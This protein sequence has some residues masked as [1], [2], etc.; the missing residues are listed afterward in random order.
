MKRFVPVLTLSLIFGSCQYLAFW[1]LNDRQQEE[2]PDFIHLATNF[3]GILV[4]STGDMY[5]C[6][7]VI[8]DYG[9]HWECRG[10]WKLDPYTGDLEPVVDTFAS[11]LKIF[12]FHSHLM[13]VLF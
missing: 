10:F 9:R 2:G 11:P 1:P 5:G 8:F 13:S 4:P 12:P 6:V 7:W 3:Y